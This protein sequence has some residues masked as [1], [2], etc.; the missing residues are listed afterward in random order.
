MSHNAAN[1]AL[2]METLKESDEWPDMQRIRC[3]GHTLQLC[4]NTALKREPI[5]HTVAAEQHL[6]GHFKREHK[7]KTGLKEKQE[8][9][10][11]PQYELIQD[12][13]TRW[14]LTYSI[15]EGLLEQRWP[16]TAVLSDPNFTKRSESSTLDLSTAQWNAAEDIRNVL[17]LMITLTELLS[18]EDITSLSAT[19]TNAGKLEKT[20]PGS[21]PLRRMIALLPKK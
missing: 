6:V 14:N 16:V 12:V 18:E 19:N 1:M 5:C 8:Q 11:V 20:P 7:A 4:I 13:S 10:N 2:C 3:A 17:K 15:L 9:Q 21:P